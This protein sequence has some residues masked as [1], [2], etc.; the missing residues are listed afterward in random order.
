MLVS[1]TRKGKCACREGEAVLQAS[2]RCQSLPL[3]R[4]RSG[5]DGVI[6]VFL[7]SLYFGGCRTLI[8]ALGAALDARQK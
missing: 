5:T 6:A 4:S 7:G 2:W 1:V 8:A 3:S